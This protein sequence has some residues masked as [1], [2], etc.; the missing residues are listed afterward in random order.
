MT[1]ERLLT[2]TARIINA[3]PKRARS[4]DASHNSS[5]FSCNHASKIDTQLLT[6]LKSNSLVAGTARGKFH[7]KLTEPGCPNED[8]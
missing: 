3:L 5:S 2:R 4:L 7:S 6:P 8:S 1:A